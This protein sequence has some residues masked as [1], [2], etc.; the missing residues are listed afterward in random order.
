MFLLTGKKALVTGASGGIGSQIAKVLHKQ[1]AHVTLSGTRQDALEAIAKELGDR[2]SIEI[3][4]LA[5]KASVASLVARAESAM[6]GLDILINNAGMTKDMLAM[7]MKD[8]DWDQVIAVNLTAAFVLSR[9]AIKIM[10][11]NRWGRIINISSIVGFTGNPGQANY[12][13][14]KAGLVGMSKSLGIEMATR[15]ITV[16]CV[17][18]GFIESNMTGKLNEQQTQAIMSKIPLQRM[19]KPEEIAAAVAFLS[20]EEAAY[21]TGQTIHVNGGMA[22]I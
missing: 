22:M 17:A 11:K 14:T 13:A 16:N 15:G 3:C 10:M 1:G 7:R 19:G 9:E 6:D 8:E 21:I 20:S 4:N 12:C 2:V 18:P 5:D